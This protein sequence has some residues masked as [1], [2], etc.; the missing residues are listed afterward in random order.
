MKRQAVPII[1]FYA[2]VWVLAGEKWSWEKMDS[3]L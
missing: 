3:F 1:D 2:R